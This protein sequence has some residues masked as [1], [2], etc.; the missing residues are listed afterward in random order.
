MLAPRMRSIAVASQWE[1]I[2]V[3]VH[4]LVMKRAPNVLV[5]ASFNLPEAPR[6]VGIGNQ[7]PIGGIGMTV[8][9]IPLVA[10]GPK[11]GYVSKSV[12]PHTFVATTPQVSELR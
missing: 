5:V 2:T 12:C 9:T 8:R 10:V 3:V 1:C 11:P 7:S 6:A 4:D